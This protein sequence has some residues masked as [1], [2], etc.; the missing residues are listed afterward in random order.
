LQ[1]RR[2]EGPDDDRFVIEGAGRFFWVSTPE[3]LV[4]RALDGTRTLDQVVGHVEKAHGLQVSMYEVESFL[5]RLRSL[6]L[7]ECASAGEPRTLGLGWSVALPEPLTIRIC[8]AFTWLANPRGGAVLVA[9]VLAAITATLV[10]WHD[11]RASFGNGLNLR[12]L[13]AIVLAGILT[14]PLHELMHGAAL[15]S[16]GERPGRLGIGL[17]RGFI[18]VM[19]IDV[20]RAWALADRGRR[21]AIWAAGLEADLLLGAL[22]ALGCAASGQWTQG[23]P[24]GLLLASGLKL[25]TN[26]NPFLG[27]DGADLMSEWCRTPAVMDKVTARLFVQ[28]SGGRR[29]MAGPDPALSESTFRRA[30]LGALAYQV[31]YLVWVAWVV[32]AI[33]LAIR[34]GTFL[35]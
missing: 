29:Y 9:I 27:G 7:L 15:I 3:L 4:M 18:P 13:A 12:A 34:T 32:W 26:A 10:W 31:I 21:I 2:E 8:S 17:Y 24:A 25:V 1:V 30:L 14:T 33:V 23:I 16:A 28:L 35:R 22:G 5:A 6:G 19:F 11:V 20:S